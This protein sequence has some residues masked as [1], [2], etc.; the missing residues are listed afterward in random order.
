M[1]DITPIALNEITAK[2]RVSFTVRSF[3]IGVLS[4][5]QGIG[6]QDETNVTTIKKSTE[7]AEIFPPI[8]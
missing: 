3:I 4:V 5:F 7:N 2:T 8:Y 1:A 6:A